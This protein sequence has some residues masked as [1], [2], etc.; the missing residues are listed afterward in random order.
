MLAVRKRHEGRVAQAAELAIG[1]VKLGLNRV[2]ANAQAAR[3]M[4]VGEAFRHQKRNLQFGF[5][6]KRFDLLAFVLPFGFA[7]QG[8]VDAGGRPTFS[9][10]DR[11]EALGD[12]TRRRVL[13]DNAP[14]PMRDGNR[15]LL[16]RAREEQ[17]ARRQS[18]LLNLLQELYAAEPRQRYAEHRDPR[19][20]LPNA[21]QRRD[22]I[23]MSFDDLEARHLPKQRA[24]SVH[25]DR[26]IIREQ[27]ARLYI[28]RKRLLAGPPRTVKVRIVRARGRLEI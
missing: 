9:A 23:A 8:V 3:D 22:A 20:V 15:H 19:L 5:R 7:A 2:F 13:W 1:V 21:L 11:R 25:I 10:G 16:L 28:L 17:D 18:F 14:G 24:K 6:E 12:G 27:N 4:R 26:V